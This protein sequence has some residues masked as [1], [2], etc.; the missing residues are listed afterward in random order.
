MPFE[1]GTTEKHKP[2]LCDTLLDVHLDVA[3]DPLGGQGSRGPYFHGLQTGRRSHARVATSYLELLFRFS[4][5]SKS[6][7]ASSVHFSSRPHGRSR[8]GSRGELKQRLAAGQEE[9]GHA[10]KRR[11]KM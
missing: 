1:L 6:Y 8:D 10:A 9:D 4:E 2:G 7:L 11:P 5:I 3:R